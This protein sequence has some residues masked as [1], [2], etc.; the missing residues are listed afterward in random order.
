MTLLIWHQ[1]VILF[2]V[3]VLGHNRF[4]V[5]RVISVDFISLETN[6]IAE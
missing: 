2:E 1:I 3:S 6:D 4:R 5:D